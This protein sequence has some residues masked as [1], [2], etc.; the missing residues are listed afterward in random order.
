VVLLC[1]KLVVKEL[2]YEVLI[3]AQILPCIRLCGGTLQDITGLMLFSSDWTRVILGV[4]DG[5]HFLSLRHFILSQY[6]RNLPIDCGSGIAMESR[7]V[8][9]VSKQPSA[10]V[11]MANQSRKIAL[12]GQLHPECGSNT[13]LRTYC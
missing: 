3:R 9:D 13:F 4:T 12:R 1:G 11:F 2:I 7:T 5:L 10:S 8:T 6:F